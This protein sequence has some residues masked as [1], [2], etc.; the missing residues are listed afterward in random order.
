MAAEIG[1]GIFYTDEE[2]FAIAMVK[3]RTDYKVDAPSLLSRDAKIQLARSLH[4][5]YN[6]GNG[7][8]ARLLRLDYS[9][10]DALFPTIKR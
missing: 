7:K 9:V 6:A 4:Y 10:V 8:I 3:C 5:D 2:L 1:E